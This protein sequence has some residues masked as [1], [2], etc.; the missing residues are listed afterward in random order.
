MTE[1]P[2]TIRITED[3]G[4][5]TVTVPRRPSAL[6]RHLIDKIAQAALLVLAVAF[7]LARFADGVVAAALIVVIVAAGWGGKIYRDRLVAGKRQQLWLTPQRIRFPEGDV[8]L[9]TVSALRIDVDR[10]RLMLHT[11][12]QKVSAVLGELEYAELLWLR[13][14]LQAHI[15]QRRADLGEALAQPAAVPEALQSLRER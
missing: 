4:G 11:D 9:E 7:I 15:D 2:S 14:F 10:G 12:D 6:A 13:G 5:I 3:I 1:A 8:L